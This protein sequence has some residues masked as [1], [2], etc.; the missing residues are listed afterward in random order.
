MQKVMT[1]ARY[2][3][4]RL[5]GVGRDRPDKEVNEMS[6]PLPDL[7]KKVRTFARCMTFHIVAISIAWIGKRGNR[8]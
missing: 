1:L 6:S 2:G 7:H 3:L 5:S 4:D 8:E